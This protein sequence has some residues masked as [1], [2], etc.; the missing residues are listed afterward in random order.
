MKQTW[1]GKLSLRW[2]WAMSSSTRTRNTVSDLLEE[3]GHRGAFK[4]GR[5]A[6][7]GRPAWGPHCFSWLGS[8]LVHS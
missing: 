2:F 7:L 3:D 1:S 5:P 6:D 8:S 4:G